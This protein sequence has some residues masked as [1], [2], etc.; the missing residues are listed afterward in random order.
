MNIFPPKIQNKFTAHLKSVIEKAEILSQEFK[1][2][3][4]GVE[5][6]FFG[7]MMQKGSI[8]YSV[9]A[10]EN[11]DPKALREIIDKMPKTKKWSLK[12]SA[13]FK[14]IFKKAVLIASRYQH[15]YVGTDHLLYAILVSKDKKVAETLLSLGIKQDE[16]REKL[17]VLMES[18]AR[19]SDFVDVF[20]LA[21]KAKEVASPNLMSGNII[22]GMMAEN[23]SANQK[24]SAL[25]YFC[26]DLIN[27]FEKKNTDPIIGREEEINK[28]INI[29]SRKTK[30]NPILVG[31]PGVGKT[32][33]V[34]GL[35]QRISQGD[36]PVNLSNKKIYSLDL[37]LLIA[38]AVYRGE[39]E[40]RLKD[41]IS[42][43]QE[44]PE[45]ILFIDEIHTI[46]GAGSAGGGSLDAANILKPP[47][48]QGKLSCIGAT[49]LD[50]YRKYFKKDA[51]LERRFQMA[52]IEEPSAEDTKKILGG[53]RNIYEAHHNLDIEEE[54]IS[55]AVE[56]SQRF[57]N[58][59]FFPDKAFDV[60]DEAASLVRSRHT[61]KN[62]LKEIKELEKELKELKAEK[63]K[64]VDNEEYDRAL[65]M[66]EKESKLKKHLKEMREVQEKENKIKIKEAVGREDVAEVIRQMTGVPVKKIVSDD[67]K[68]LQNLEKEL[69]KR[70]EGQDEA[71]SV[72]AKSIRRSRS[73]VANA[74]RP[75]GV[76]M[77]LGP[78]G[79]GKTEL[80]K[81]L[82]ET[83][84][85]KS[86]A[87]IKVDM[88]EFMEK[89]NVS[90]LVGA[91]A[92]YVGYEEGGKLTEQVRLHPYSVILFD[93]IEKA[94]PDVF[95]LM[96]QI[97]EDGELTDASGRKVDFRNTTIIMTSNI[98]TEQL[99]S[100]AKW[101][102]GENKK[103]SESKE[104]N[105][106]RDKY[107]ETKDAVLKELK[108][109]LSPEFINRIDRVL[110]FNPLSEA[111]LKN[112]VR[113]Q[114]NDFKIRLLKNNN[115]KISADQK[116]LDYISK[117]SFDPNEGARLAR[118][119]LQEMVEDLVSE[120]IIDGKIGE[121]DKIRL[122]I[123]SGKLEIC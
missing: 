18:S 4:I 6:I 115:I 40:A 95:N 93:E 8:G 117:K 62:Y 53:L 51:A 28:T 42:E 67:R 32:A 101:G 54:A 68:K 33:V 74:D 41:V 108:E 122:K 70:I 23:P 88:S 97:F 47:L 112:I 59:R 80:A 58:D 64:A 69:K 29:L 104:K 37:G 15:N 89:H 92:G 14:N 77:F 21:G 34:Q 81:V 22:N 100:E 85:E 63:E 12:L 17:K 1:H 98:G 116:A 83:I 25:E 5:H 61:G 3:S 65:L 44:N 118:R 113:M 66:K 56:L 123:K 26:V 103:I 46:I 87:L 60:L 78:T 20:D 102:F 121:G 16:L 96:L 120:K 52:L 119:N 86:D 71:V 90:R 27:E 38:G 13:E 107:I 72:I 109:I 48:S 9:L 39:F 114:F 7:L 36:V 105:R 45:V 24:Q 49:T 43:A 10:G 84:Y 91:P 57:I 82:A 76:F 50:E 2:Q 19:F 31:E 75:A 111:N 30:S 55:S 35:A 106:I 94:H 73:G 79:V 11:V 110:V 99:T